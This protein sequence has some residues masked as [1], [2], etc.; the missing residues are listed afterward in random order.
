MLNAHLG[1]DERDPEGDHGDGIDACLAVA[2]AR[3]VAPRRDIAR[4]THAKLNRQHEQLLFLCGWAS[5]CRGY[6][7]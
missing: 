6:R 3:E 7:R 5:H 1:E 4:E 2:Q